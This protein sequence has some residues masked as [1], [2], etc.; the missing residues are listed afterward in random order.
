MEKELQKLIKRLEKT[1]DGDSNDA[2]HDAA[3]E[4][5]QY[6]KDHDKNERK[7]ERVQHN[8]RNS[9]IRAMAQEE[10]RDG[11]LEVDDGAIVS[12][13]EDNGAYV[14]AWVWVDFYGTPLNK[15]KEK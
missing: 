4:L 10:G 8:K 3:F 11:E 13:G 5:V 2:E 14:Q 1:F 12:E 6:L 15:E 7:K 9:A